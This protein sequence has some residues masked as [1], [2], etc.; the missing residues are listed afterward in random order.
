MDGRHNDTGQ[1]YL[2]GM[3]CV[4]WLRVK[5]PSVHSPSVVQGDTTGSYVSALAILEGP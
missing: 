1:K 3:M 5:A 2:G 4:A